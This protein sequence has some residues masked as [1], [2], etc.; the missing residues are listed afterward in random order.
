M[1]D[2]GTFYIKGYD[3]GQPHEML[4]AMLQARTSD[5]IEARAPLSW[6]QRTEAGKAVR[7]AISKATREGRARLKARGKL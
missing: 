2:K 1:L 4:H 7:S 3:F 5:I 6:M